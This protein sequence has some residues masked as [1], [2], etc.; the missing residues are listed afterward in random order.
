MDVLER[1]VEGFI[2]KR[3]EID[4]MMCGFVSGRGTTEAIFIVRQLQ[5]KH[6]TSN[7]PLYMTFVD[8]EKA[9]DRVQRDVI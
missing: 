5:V 1:V 4:V 7:N 6:L 8:L 2:R 9:F 3:V